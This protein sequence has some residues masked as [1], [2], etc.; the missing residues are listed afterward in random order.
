M[1]IFSGFIVMIAVTTWLGVAVVFSGLKLFW[2]AILVC[3]LVV[4][5]A[6]DTFVLNQIYS[7]SILASH[8][9]NIALLLLSQTVVVTVVLLLFRYIGFELRQQDAGCAEARKQSNV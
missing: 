3:S 1:V 4:L 5:P 2:S 9:L 8:F 6:F 7:N